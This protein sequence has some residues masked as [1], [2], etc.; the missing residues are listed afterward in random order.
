MH[1]EKLQDL[2][3]SG[4]YPRKWFAGYTKMSDADQ[5]AIIQRCADADA[6]PDEDAAP[7]A[8]VPWSH[9]DATHA[10]RGVPEGLPT[11]ALGYPVGVQ[12]IATRTVPFR[13]AAARTFRRGT[14]WRGEFA[15]DLWD[16]Y[17]S[18][19]APLAK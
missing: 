12:I 7:V 16:Q 11:T 5:L 3:S 17:R 13:G 9:P 14:I 8:T 4:K 2:K 19:V 10:D 6:G 1:T 18:L 15:W